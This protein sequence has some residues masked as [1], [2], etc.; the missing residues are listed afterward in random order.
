MFKVGLDIGYGHTKVVTEDGKRIIFP[1]IAKKGEAIDLDNLLGAK[2]DYIIN[3]NDTTW[4]IGK[5]AQKESSFAT[6]AFEQTDRYNDEAF[7]A[8]LST[9]LSLATQ[10]TE[11]DVMLVTGLPL[12]IYETSQK[13]FCGFLKGFSAHTEWNGT[14][15][16]VKVKDAIVFPQAGGIFFSPS[17]TDIKNN[18]PENSL[19]T[20]IDIGYRTTDCASFNFAKGA[21]HFLIENSFT[22]DIGMSSVFRP[23][24][25]A[26][27]KKVGSIDIS[28]EES[29]N[30]YQKGICFKNNK[31]VDMSDE[32]NLLKKSI[33]ANINEG[34]RSNAGQGA[35]INNIILA[36]GGSIALRDEL[37][38]IFP[39][40]ISV[41]DTQM[42]NALGFL[43]I[44]H[45]FDL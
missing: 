7:Q 43:S 40:A 35:K 29:E 37:L 44:A 5:M 13:E 15:K 42:A 34:Y 17:C 18:L 45:R 14:C 21:F 36:G 9:A 23:L 25:R 26:I 19:I 6:R 8:M 33:A 1:S 24:S 32:I 3:I 2:E 28:L 22:L 27:A 41:T 30:V 39:E 31:P 12:S 38:N 16:E 4:Y 11:Q 10:G 20:V